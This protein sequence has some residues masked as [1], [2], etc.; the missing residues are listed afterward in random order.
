MSRVFDA[1]RTDIAFNMTP[2]IDVTFQLIIFFILAGSF[3][4]LDNIRLDVPAPEDSAA[5]KLGEKNL[6]INVPPYP[7][8]E[9]TANPDLA[10]RARMWRIS[11]EEL[12]PGETT[13]LR[14]ILQDARKAYAGPPEEFKVEIRADESIHYS[15]IQ[16]ILMA[17]ADAGIE[18]MQITAKEPLGAGGS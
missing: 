6:V 9:L 11:T 1:K 13:R 17:A 8:T 2:M 16:P 4:S 14:Q 15:A 7:K 12:K 18:K 10:G 5:R 3:A